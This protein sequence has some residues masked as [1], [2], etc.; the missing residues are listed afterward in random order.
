M[1]GFNTVIVAPCVSLFNA[2]LKNWDTEFAFEVEK[3]PNCLTLVSSIVFMMLCEDFAFHFGHR[4]LHWKF[5]Y[6]YI[7]KIHHTHKTTIG[8]AAEYAH[9]IEFIF[10]NMIPTFLGAIILG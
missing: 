3:L 9:P 5:I 1:V 2:Y 8:I 7:H 6:P 10:A 4:L